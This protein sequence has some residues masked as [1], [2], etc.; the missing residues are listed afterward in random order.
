M[1][2]HRGKHRI[3]AF[4]GLERGNP[5]VQDIACLHDME[6][7]Q[8]DG[9]KERCN[10][11]LGEARTFENGLL[12]VHVL[13]KPCAMYLVQVDMGEATPVTFV[14]AEDALSI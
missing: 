11:I 1:H 2:L 8:V 9:R 12:C 5:I 13:L 6:S 4:V 14:K 10:E 7:V 3:G